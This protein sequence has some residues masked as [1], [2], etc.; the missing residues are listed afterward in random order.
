MTMPKVGVQLYTVREHMQTYEDTE[1]LFAFLKDLG[2]SVI[3][4]SGIGPIEPDKVAYL[5][6]KYGMDVCV[7]HKPFDRMLN[8][9]DALIDE[10]LLMHCDCIGIGGMPSE[11]RK[12]AEG[13]REFIAQ[14]NDIGRK[15]KARGVRFAYHNHAFEFEK[16]GDKTIMDM[17]IEETD[18]EVFFFIPDVYWIQ[19][20]GENP[21]EY[22]KK[23][24]GRVKVC[25]F[26][27][28]EITT[29]CPMITELGEGEVDLD[30]CFKACMELDIPYI[31]YEQD[32]NF[33]EDALTSTRVSYACLEELVKA[34]S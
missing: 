20:G 27:D 12:T 26:K 22:L 15:M 31:V 14:A 29:S 3:Q 30:A 2:V 11:N 7:T 8:D 19:V 21:A 6:D 1:T 13:V 10:H 32:N 17:L 28:G 4:I 33:D 5:V 34:N 24:A 18:P 25:H 16:V 23:L 9:L